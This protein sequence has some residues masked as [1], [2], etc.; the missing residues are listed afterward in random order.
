MQGW[1]KALSYFSFTI[2]TSHW[3]SSLNLHC[4]RICREAASALEST[5]T[6]P[7]FRQGNPNSKWSSTTC[8]PIVALAVLS[9]PRSPPAS[10]PSHWHSSG[11]RSQAD[12]RVRRCRSSRW[13]HTSRT[14]RVTSMPHPAQR[15]RRRSDLFLVP[16]SRV[17][18][19]S[20]VSS[21]SLAGVS[22]PA[23]PRAASGDGATGAGIAGTG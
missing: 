7:R 10:H 9:G 15:Q 13:V 4:R 5:F 16:G 2:S 11:A 14:L 1:A 20:S 6:H 3:D 21:S 17:R 8:L 19:T 22:G 18:R 23:R 12:R